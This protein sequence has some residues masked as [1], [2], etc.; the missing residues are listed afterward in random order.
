MN[1]EY[2]WWWCVAACTSVYQSAKRIRRYHDIQLFTLRTQ[3][4]QGWVSTILEPGAGVTSPGSASRGVAPCSETIVISAWSRT[5][6]GNNW[7][8]PL[9][10][11]AGTF[12]NPCKHHFTNSFKRWPAWYT[13]TYNLNS[14]EEYS[15][16]PDRLRLLRGSVPSMNVP[17]IVKYTVHIKFY[18]VI[19]INNISYV[20][21]GLIL[22]SEL[23]TNFP[24]IG[25][26]K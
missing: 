15:S 11:T 4:W 17:T 26:R 13:K 14:L 16:K 20:T 1:R 22:P 25:K 7:I 23:P 2:F 6:Y 10:I 9:S 18:S 5:N 19:H 3:S 12:P 21:T 8:V 24:P